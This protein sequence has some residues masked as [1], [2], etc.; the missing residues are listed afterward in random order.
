MQFPDKD[1]PRERKLQQPGCPLRCLLA[2]AATPQLAAAQNDSAGR[3]ASR[4][5]GS[6]GGDSKSLTDGA[7]PASR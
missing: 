7:G 4:G 2:A 1:S 5:D 6:R 3:A